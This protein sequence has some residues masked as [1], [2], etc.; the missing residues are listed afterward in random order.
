MTAVKRRKVAS[1]T[2]LQA[3]NPTN[4]ILPGVIDKL[5]NRGWGEVKEFVNLPTLARK[6]KLKSLVTKGRGAT[7]FPRP[8]LFPGTLAAGGKAIQFYYLTN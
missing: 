2:A 8:G 4:G 7:P 1:Q 6:L 3:E 5:T